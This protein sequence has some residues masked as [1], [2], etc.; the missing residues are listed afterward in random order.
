M[1]NFKEMYLPITEEE[2]RQNL[3]EIEE[4]EKELDDLVEFKVISKAVRRAIGR[5]M[6]RLA[7]T[8]AFKR[9]KEL[10]RRVVAKG[11][12]LKKKAFNMAKDFVIKKFFPLYKKASMEMRVKMDQQIASK[13]GGLLA[14]MTQ[15]KMKDAK[16]AEIEKVKAYRRSIGKKDA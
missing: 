2:Y 6:K 5:R 11:A 8:A 16:K 12:K 3:Q 15:K 14:K 9:A 13:Y 1:R 7:K 10:G 4:I